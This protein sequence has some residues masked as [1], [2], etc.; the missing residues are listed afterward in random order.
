[1]ESKIEDFLFLLDEY[2]DLKIDI[3]NSKTDKEK[4]ELINELKITEKEIKILLT[5]LDW[6]ENE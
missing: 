2:V 1:M 5:W 4:M 3:R 6:K